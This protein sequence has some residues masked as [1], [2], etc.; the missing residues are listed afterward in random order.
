MHPIKRHLFNTCCGIPRKPL[1]WG[2]G[3]HSPAG[4]PAGLCSAELISLSLDVSGPPLHRGLTPF[5]RSEALVGGSPVE[6]RGESCA[7]C[8]EPVKCGHYWAQLCASWSPRTGGTTEVASLLLYE[9]GETE[10]EQLVFAE[11]PGHCEGRHA[12]AH[13]AQPPAHALVPG[14]G[15]RSAAGSAE[16]RLREQLLGAGRKPLQARA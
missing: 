10:K 14:G 16:P 7:H 15:R 2:A 8:P 5:L 3:V 1:P 12:Q 6:V 4:C 11:F 13:A 9:K